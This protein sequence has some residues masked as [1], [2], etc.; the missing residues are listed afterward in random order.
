M[1]Q[2]AYQQQQQEWQGELA[3]SQ[4]SLSQVV[5]VMLVT[6]SEN[7]PNPEDDDRHAI[8]S[9]ILKWTSVKPDDVPREWQAQV[10]RRKS[11]QISKDHV[12]S[13]NEA[14][15][16][17]LVFPTANLA[18]VVSMMVAQRPPDRH[19]SR[20]RV[21]ATGGGALRFRHDLETK[22]DIDME[23]VNELKAVSYGWWSDVQD[24]DNVTY[25]ALL[26][27]VGT[28]VS[29]ISVDKDGGFERVSGSGLGGA[30][31][32]GLVKR[33]TKFS[34]FDECIL[35]A[36]KEGDAGRADTLVG[37]IYGV[38]TSKEIG[39][40]ADLVA[41]FLGKADS[42]NITDSDIAAAL[43]RM[44]TNN[45]GQLVV[46]QAR[47]MGINSVWFTGGFFQQHVADIG[48]N[49]GTPSAFESAPVATVGSIVQNAV[50]EAVNFWSAGKIQPL[51]SSDASIL[52][53]L[54]AVAALGSE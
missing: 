9:F 50:S 25:P 2:Y 54:G 8:E 7:T 31:F 19:S 41:G 37:D 15:L 38:E 17:I 52:G 12:V 44:V 28:G 46:F 26:C 47:A 45:L 1:R 11:R 40:P 14:V 33:M 43:L 48:G 3:D 23:M 10:I 36:H 20:I 24:A 39:M 49:A 5:V 13:D 34:S 18:Q 21:A 29:M 4:D 16:R 32:W 22:L 30:T 51:F 27:N 6:E 35:A 42:E 53:A